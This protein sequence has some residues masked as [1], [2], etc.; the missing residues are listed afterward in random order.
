M[1][2]ETYGIATSDEAPHSKL[3]T[4]KQKLLGDQ[5]KIIEKKLSES[6]KITLNVLNE[7]AENLYG[8]IA[9][10]KKNVDEVIL[11]QLDS[12]IPSTYVTLG[13]RYG[14][15]RKKI[16]ED[17]ELNKYFKLQE[18]IAID[19]SELSTSAKGKDKKREETEQIKKRLMAKKIQKAKDK[20]EGADVAQK[21]SKKQTELLNEQASA[22]LNRE[23]DILIAKLKSKDISSKRPRIEPIIKIEDLQDLI[24]GDKYVELIALSFISA[25]NLLTDIQIG[26]NKSVNNEKNKKLYELA[27]GISHLYDKLNP[28]STNKIELNKIT[29]VDS[30]AVSSEILE[31]LFSAKENFLR[32]LDFKP[33]FLS[34]NYPQLI[35]DNAYNKYLNINSIKPYKS[36]VQVLAG[37]IDANNS[38]TSNGFL[39]LLKTLTGEGKTSLIISLANTVNTILASRRINPDSKDMEI[40]FCCNDRLNT[41]SYQVGQYAYGMNVPFGMATEIEKTNKAGLKYKDVHIDNNNNCKRTKRL[42]IIADIISTARL[43]EKALR[44]NK[45]YVLFFDEPT[46]FLD[47]NNPEAI[48]HLTNIFKYLPPNVIFS[49]ATLPKVEEIAPFTTYFKTKY[50]EAKIMSVES[51]KVKIGCQVNDLSGKLFIPNSGIV[52]E[53]IMEILM[54]KLTETSFVKKLYTPY[55]VSLLWNNIEKLI[56][57]GQITSEDVE[58]FKVKFGNPC[59]LNQ[60]AVQD[61]AIN[62]L[63]KISKTANSELTSQFNTYSDSDTIIEEPIDFN[64][65]IKYKETRFKTQ[66]LIVTKNPIEFVKTYFGK[67]FEDIFEKSQKRSRDKSGKTFESFYDI[68]LDYAKQ[69]IIYEEKLAQ[70][71]MGTEEQRIRNQETI[72]RFKPIFYFERQN[73]LNVNYYPEKIDCENMDKEDNLLLVGLALGVGIYSPTTT[74]DR[75]KNEVLNLA[76]EGKLAYIV[77]DTDIAYGTNYAIEHIIIDDTCFTG[78]NA[79]SISTLFQVIARAGRVGKSWRAMIYCGTGVINILDNYT[80]ENIKTNEADKIN[81]AVE[82]ITPKEIKEEHEKEKELKDGVAEG[83]ETEADMAELAKAQASVNQDTEKTRVQQQAFEMEST[84]VAST[85][86]KPPLPMI[87]PTTETVAEVVAEVVAAESVPTEPVVVEPVVVEPVVVEPVPSATTIQ[88]PPLP[89]LGWR[90]REAL[91]KSSGT[92]TASAS[93]PTASSAP[94]APT[95]SAR[96]L[97]WREQAELRQSSRMP[98]QV[99]STAPDIKSLPWREREALKKFIPM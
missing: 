81:Q 23:F 9:I 39:C 72:D 46:S 87:V 35:F 59:N 57:S 55:V 98:T 34:K 97:S 48:V 1:D 30:G 11:N 96:P 88:K 43:L 76:S 67:V 41:V 60:E 37:L 50:P 77:A 26:E 70:L 73:I 4:G 15:L 63:G 42:L 12:K 94:T 25:V 18:M 69:Q 89:I 95:A 54:N 84:D 13:D 28:L 45:D 78:T 90:E 29:I 44:K 74:S 16:T 7:T 38:E 83:K 71:K 6:A 85:T 24:Y 61:C 17:R 33:V 75:Y 62:Y 79:H 27:L 65:L 51:S 32:R 93:V 66:T 3:L 5:W 99:S 8:K 64:K 80:K 14:D 2:S 58:N 10:E 52:Y 68:F 86:G 92:A 47:E 31:D 49:S 91:K 22:T 40:I 21:V 19:T 20:K 56:R 82:N 53:H 36:Q